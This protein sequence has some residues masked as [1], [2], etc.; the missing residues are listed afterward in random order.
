MVDQAM[1]ANQAV[2]KLVT[3]RDGLA[4]VGSPHCS[5]SVLLGREL[6]RLATPVVT[7]LLRTNLLRCKL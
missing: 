6:R 5:G 1:N 3:P 4:V 7:T 2:R